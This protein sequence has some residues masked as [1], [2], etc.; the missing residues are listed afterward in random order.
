MFLRQQLQKGVFNFTQL[1]NQQSNSIVYRYKPQR[2][3]FDKTSYIEDYVERPNKYHKSRKPKQVKW[4]DPNYT[5]PPVYPHPT[6]LQGSSLIKEV[7]Q[8]EKL[9]IERQREFKVPDFRAGDI[10]QFHFLKSISEGYGNTVTGMCTA[11]YKNNSL[12]AGFDCVFRFHGVEVFMHVKQNSPLLTDL[13]VV[14]KSHG[15][16]R[17]KLNYFWNDRTNTEQ[18]LK[19]AIVKGGHKKGKRTDIY[20][21]RRHLEQ[22]KSNVLDRSEDPVLTY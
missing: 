15:I 9:A 14:D 8:R 19:K 2:S 1:V 4:D 7:E 21:E 11:R 17:Q 10:I 12:M 16:I 20:M 6:R 13:K 3:L 22:S 18:E 5:W